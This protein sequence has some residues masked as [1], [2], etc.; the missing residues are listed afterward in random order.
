MSQIITATF[1]DGVLKPSQPLNLPSPSQVRL[2]IEL[3]EGDVQKAQQEA[4]R[5][6]EDLWRHS[7]IYSQEAHLTRDQLHERR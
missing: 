4:L 3:L 7:T 6:L 1:E 5:A 2:T